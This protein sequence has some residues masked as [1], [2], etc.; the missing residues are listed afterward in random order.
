MEVY[1]LNKRKKFHKNQIR[2]DKMSLELFFRHETA[3]NPF[4]KKN[5]GIFQQKST[6]LP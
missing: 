4:V 6:A 3:N 1:K 2:L 5:T